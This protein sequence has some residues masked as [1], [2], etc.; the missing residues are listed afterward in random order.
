MKRLKKQFILLSVLSICQ[1]LV[2]TGEPGWVIAWGG[3][4]SGI[5]TSVFSNNYAAGTITVA[6][7]MLS[8]TV[9]V[10]AGSAHCVALKQDGSVV[11]W[12]WNY[13]GQA[14]APTGLNNVVSIAAGENYSMALKRDGT[15]VAWGQDEPLPLANVPDSF[16]NVVAIAAGAS[17]AMALKRDGAIANWGAPQV[18]DGL[19]NVVAIAA[20]TYYYSHNLALQRDGALVEWGPNGNEVSTPNGL[21]NIT[22]IAV[23]GNYC[24]ALKSNGIVTE[25]RSGSSQC[26]EMLSNVTAI[27][28]FGNYNLAL[29]N[30]GT[31]VGWGHDRFYPRTVPAGLSNVVAIAVGGDFCL[32]I[33]TNCAVAEKFRQK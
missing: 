8:N 7:Q 5:S 16:S 12:G 25:W 4:G 3:Y 24:T 17:H 2:A 33:T 26:F 20:G 15:V 1:S 23:I 6:G 14:T 21:T 29:K 19:S 9:S 13:Y 11:C 28:A 18:P 32:A 10:A 30:D 27:A 22:A 31:V